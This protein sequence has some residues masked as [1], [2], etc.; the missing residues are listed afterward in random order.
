MIDG[1]RITPL[2]RFADE[3]GSVMH[4][5]RRD[6]PAFAGFGEVYFSTVRPRAVKAWRRH[7]LMTLNCAVP[8]GR[9]R[10]VLYDDRDGSPTRGQVHQLVV[11]GDHYVLL[12]VPPRIWSG[13]MG[14]SEETA[15]VCN[16]A[17]IPHD[18]AEVERR[19][20]YDPAIPY[21]W[22]AAAS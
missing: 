4:M 19:E 15:I 5:L 3:R 21:D 16:C 1:V 8:Q 10:F 18:P 9:V 2:Q 14:V 20:P 12:T 7:H 11:G 13:F 17:S 22:S 6:W